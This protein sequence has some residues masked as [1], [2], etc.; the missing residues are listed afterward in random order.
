[1]KAGVL[2]A[3]MA[4]A[5]G[6]RQCFASSGAPNGSTLDP[7]ILQSRFEKELRFNLGNPDRADLTLRLW[8]EAFFPEKM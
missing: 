8:L 7:N 5:S 6:A 2:A 3:S 1:M 4:K